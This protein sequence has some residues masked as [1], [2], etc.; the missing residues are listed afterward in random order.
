VDLRPDVI[1]LSVEGTKEFPAPVLGFLHVILKVM[2]Y[3]VFA[4]AIRRPG[5]SH[6]NDNPDQFSSFHFLSSRR[7]S[8][9]A[10]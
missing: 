2:Y 4:L 6:I 1:F 3:L 7:L 9:F 10:A 5:V 8:E